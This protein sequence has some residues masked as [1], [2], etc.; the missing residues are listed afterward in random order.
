MNDTFAMEPGLLQQVPVWAPTEDFN[1]F[2]AGSQTAP[3]NIDTIEP[4][5]LG[6]SLPDTG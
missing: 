5:W 1:V 6:A 2:F 4:S 3:T